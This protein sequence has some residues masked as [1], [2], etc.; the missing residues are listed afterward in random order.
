VDDEP[1]SEIDRDK[2]YA[3]IR[4]DHTAKNDFRE[5]SRSLYN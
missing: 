5:L 3:P 4:V 1:S 2:L